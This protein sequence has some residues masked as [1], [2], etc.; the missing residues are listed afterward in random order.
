MQKVILSLLMIFT[1]VTTA[2]AGKVYFGVTGG[3]T[4]LED[5]TFDYDD[6]ISEFEETWETDTGFNVGG[7]V[8]YDFGNIRTAFEYTFRRNELD[9]GDSEAL[10]GI[11]IDLDGTFDV[12]T[13]MA[14]AYYDFHNKTKLTPYI[15]TGIGLAHFNVSD[16]TASVGGFSGS[17]PG[18]SDQAFAYKFEGGADYAVTPNVSL[19]GAYEFVGTAKKDYGDIV[20]YE[21]SLASHNF[22]AG[23][24]YTF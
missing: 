4:V 22:K 5:T 7:T 6:G 23:L 17:A 14:A 18:G 12:H 2:H 21:A 20:D 10:P 24:R 16:V 3:V 15:G 13:F 11:D 9:E 8:G 19:T 1:M